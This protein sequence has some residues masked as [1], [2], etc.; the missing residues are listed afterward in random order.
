MELRGRRL[1][2]PLQLRHG[3]LLKSTSSPWPDGTTKG[4]ANDLMMSSKEEVLLRNPTLTR[5]DDFVEVG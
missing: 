5:S 4:T 2:A 1:K 3:R